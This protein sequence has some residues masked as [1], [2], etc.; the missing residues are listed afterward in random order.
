M[1]ADLAESGETIRLSISWRLAVDIL[2]VMYIKE[3][4]MLLFNVI[5]EAVRYGLDGPGI[6]SQWGRDF[7]HPSRGA[8][9]FHPTSYTMGTGSL[10]SG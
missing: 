9:G 5:F 8:L 7:P 4:Q 10:S 6:E 2:H 1:S 3:N